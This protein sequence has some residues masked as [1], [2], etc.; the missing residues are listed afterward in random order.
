LSIWVRC[1]NLSIRNLYYHTI[2]KKSILKL[3]LHL[4]YYRQNTTYNKE[5]H[6]NRFR[7]LVFPFRLRQGVCAKSPYVKSL[8][9]IMPQVKKPISSSI[10]DIT[11]RMFTGILP[12]KRPILCLVSQRSIDTIRRSRT[13]A[14]GYSIR[15]WRNHRIRVINPTC[16]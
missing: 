14:T 2:V 12:Y 15:C 10:V 11:L 1:P 7:V 13:T 9:P 3:Y 5:N 8:I 4:G 6:R 16:F